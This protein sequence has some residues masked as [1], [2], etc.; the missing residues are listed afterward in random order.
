MPKDI[1]EKV[2][3]FFYFKTFF[4]KGFLIASYS[5]FL[6]IMVKFETYLPTFCVK[7]TDI[8]ENTELQMK[9]I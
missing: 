8:C 5:V 1:A 6:Q 9:L 3:V 2:L 7:E 4:V